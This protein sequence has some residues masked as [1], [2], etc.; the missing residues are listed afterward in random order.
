MDHMVANGTLSTDSLFGAE[1]PQKYVGKVLG[2]PGPTWFSGGIFQNPDILNAP[3]G[4]I[5][6]GLPLY[7]EGEDKV[8]GN[9]GGGMWYASSHSKNFDAVATFLKFAVSSDT[10]VK[11]ITGLPAYQDTA[12]KWLDAQ[13]SGGYW[14]NPDTFKENVST[15]ATSVWKD[16]GTASFSVETG[17]AKVIVPGLAAGKTIK[18]L[19]PEWETEIKNE[20]Q[21]QGYTVK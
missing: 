3:A 8:T 7:W 11:L 6:A 18:E 2:M 16:W 4:T 1:F 17:Y 20:A 19:A 12:D 14:S 15:A 5:G 9:V 13:V 10:A 21:A